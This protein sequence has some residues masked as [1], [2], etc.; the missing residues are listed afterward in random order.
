MKEVLAVV[1]SGNYI[2]PII[3]AATDRCRTADHQLVHLSTRHYPWLRACAGTVRRCAKSYSAKYRP[4]NIHT[5]VDVD[6]EKRGDAS[7]FTGAGAY[8]VTTALSRR[9]HG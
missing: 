5:H 8:T 3:D 7:S 6:G 9:R 4:Y 2:S 1:G